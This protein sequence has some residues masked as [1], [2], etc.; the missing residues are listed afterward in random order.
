MAAAAPL[1]PPSPLPPLRLTRSLQAVGTNGELL[2]MCGET[3]S[4]LRIPAYRSVP[5]PPSPPP[6]VPPPSVPP[7]SLPPPCWLFLFRDC[8]FRLVGGEDN[9]AV[10]PDGRPAHGLLPTPPRPCCCPSATAAPQ[11]PAAP[12]PAPLCS[13]AGCVSVALK[14][15]SN[16]TAPP[17]A[18]LVDEDPDARA[19]VTPDAAQPSARGCRSFCFCLPFPFRAARSPCTACCSIFVLFRSRVEAA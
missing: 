10:V 8:C 3:F 14:P 2:G 4:W 16:L 11:A 13:P 1:P 17:G 19:D 18:T 15:G 9:D 5:N 12:A 7:F 6:S